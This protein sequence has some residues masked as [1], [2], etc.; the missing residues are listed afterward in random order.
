MKKEI[1]K[2]SL[3]VLH[4]FYWLIIIWSILISWYIIWKEIVVRNLNLTKYSSNPIVV[5]N[6]E[7]INTKY[8]ILDRYVYV[9]NKKFYIYKR[10]LENSTWDNLTWKKLN[11]K[12]YKI[13]KKEI[14]NLE[15]NR[16]YKQNKKTNKIVNEKLLYDYMSYNW[17]VIDLRMDL[18]DQMDLLNLLDEYNVWP[19]F[20]KKNNTLYIFAHSSWK[21]FNLW[22]IFF[23]MKV[24]D[25]VI[26]FDNQWQIY[27]TY[28]IIKRNI[29]PVKKFENDIF[30][31]FKNK[32]VFATCYPFNS[33]SH[34][35]YLVLVKTNN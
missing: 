10:V 21:L 14:N 17:D 34:R 18:M 20:D 1:K 13:I 26:F 27:D 16:I 19:Y 7:K 25:K 33:T 30:L 11:N 32:I 4:I 12:K 35:L 31:T 28:K 24:W 22:K 3:T 29:V 8:E 2:M 9:T 23:K 5:I 15:L 6:R